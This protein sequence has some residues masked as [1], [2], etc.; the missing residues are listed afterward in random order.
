MI[1]LFKKNSCK[2]SLLGLAT[3]LLISTFALTNAK[4]NTQETKNITDTYTNPTLENVDVNQ[5]M[6]VYFAQSEGMDRGQHEFWEKEVVVDR[7]YYDKYPIKRGDVVL[8]KTPEF[9]Y[10]KN[11]DLVAAESDVSRIIGLPGEKIKIVKGQIYVDD[12]RLDTFYGKALSRGLDKDSYPDKSNKAIMEYFET[13]MEEV[14]IP[15]GHIF[16]LGDT[17]WRS[18]DSQIFGPLPK[19]NIVGKVLGYVDVAKREPA[20]PGVYNFK[21]KLK[22]TIAYNKN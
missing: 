9:K 16:I 19:Q 22:L 6:I 10:Q 7:S 13:N 11:P 18:I 2:W 15:D 3:I 17:W 20:D 4:T 5:D 21:Q 12:K 8:Y 1:T 14:K